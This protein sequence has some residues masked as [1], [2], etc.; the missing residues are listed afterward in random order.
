M[1]KNYIIWS[2]IIIIII[3]ICKVGT[4]VFVLHVINIHVIMLIIYLFI[5]S[6]KPAVGWEI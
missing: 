5:F 4:A 3:I 2:N 6:H 1:V